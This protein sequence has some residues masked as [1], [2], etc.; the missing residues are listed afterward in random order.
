MFALA[1]AKKPLHKI[2]G[3]LKRTAFSIMSVTNHYIIILTILKTMVVIKRGFNN[4]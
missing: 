1:K 3:K 4:R 2:R